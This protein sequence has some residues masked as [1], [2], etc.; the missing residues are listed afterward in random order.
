MKT[1]LVT[2]DKLM[3]DNKV[4]HTDC[5]RIM[6]NTPEEAHAIV[7]NN[8]ELNYEQNFRISSIEELK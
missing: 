6:A 3:C 5:F 8:L 1:F 7:Q 2:V 4:Y